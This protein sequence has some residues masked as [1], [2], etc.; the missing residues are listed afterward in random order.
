MCNISTKTYLKQIKHIEDLVKE[1]FDEKTFLTKFLKPL[2]NDVAAIGS[3]PTALF[4]FL[5]A[6]N[7][8]DGLC[9]TNAFQ[10]TLE[11]AMM[12]GGD[13]DTIMSMAGA[14]AGAFYGETAIPEYLVNLC[15][16]VQ[17]AQTQA[18]MLHELVT[19][20]NGKV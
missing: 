10:R 17:D 4:C 2:G 8:I 9:D 3:A 19:S 15:E 13:A 20:E 5:K 11:L 14:I 18:E 1:D 6:Q 12:F 7:Q 16:G